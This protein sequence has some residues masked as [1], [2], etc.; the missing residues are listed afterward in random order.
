MEIG[1]A[2]D[3]RIIFDA[4]NA[5]KR[6]FYGAHYE[7]C[8]L[9]EGWS[10]LGNGS[11]R[12]VWCSPS[13]VAYKV[14]HDEDGCD[15]A[16]EY[17][18]YVRIMQECDLPEGTRVPACTLHEVEEDRWII[19][20]EKVNGKTVAAYQDELSDEIGWDEAKEK[21]KPIYKLMNE[22]EQE[23]CIWDMHSENAMIDENGMVVFVDL[24]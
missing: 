18:N 20:V 23:T 24:Q 12:S 1:N 11:Y 14:A 13:G 4:V 15:N 17:E 2:E 8:P 3:A 7:D 16:D 9:P 19:A 5:W 21:C 22:L 6:P 10:F